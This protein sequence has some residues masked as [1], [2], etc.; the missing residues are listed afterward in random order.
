MANRFV[1]NL[2]NSRTQAHIFHLQTKSYSQHK[3]LQLYYESIIPLV[4]AWAEAYMG[5][6]GK[7]IKFNR[8]TRFIQDPAKIKQYFR[9]LLKRIKSVK[10]PKDSHL[11]NI[12]DEIIALIESTLYLLSL[13]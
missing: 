1:G 11:M 9:D 10:V 12:R 7:T 3:A 4:D 5:T 13:S 2:F 6:Y 8:N